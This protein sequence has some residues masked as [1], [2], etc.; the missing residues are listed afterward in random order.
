M[1]F[2]RTIPSSTA[3]LRAQQSATIVTM[4]M[5]RSKE[6]KST[7]CTVRCVSTDPADRGPGTADRGPKRP[8]TEKTGDRGPGTEK[9]GDR[10]PGTADRGPKRPGTEKTGDRGPGT[11]KTGDRGP[12]TEDRRPKRPGTDP[13]PVSGL[14]SPVSGLPS[15][16]SRLLHKLAPNLIAILDTFFKHR[17]VFLDFYIALR[18]RQQ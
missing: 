10:G 12:G 11:E 8:G 1:I 7:R 3:V 4:L 16:V 17:P 14:P 18:T 2:T 15:P 5:D 6:A 13:P 9:T